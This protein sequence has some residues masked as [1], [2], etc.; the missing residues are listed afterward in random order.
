MD[1]L[2]R[3][4]KSS[5][6]QRNDFIGLSDLLGVSAVVDLVDGRDSEGATSAMLL[7]PFYVPGQPDITSGAGLIKD[8]PRERLV[9]RG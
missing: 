2:L 5:S 6:D 7:E 3:A 9:L 8:N 4:A 1:F